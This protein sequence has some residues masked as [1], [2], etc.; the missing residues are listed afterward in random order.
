MSW[1]KHIFDRHHLIGTVQRR[2]SSL[3]MEEKIYVITREC[4]A[5]FIS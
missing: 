2:S 5:Q 3:N 1:F 4:Q